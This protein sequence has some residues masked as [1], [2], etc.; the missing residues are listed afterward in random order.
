MLG[1]YKLKEDSRFI[2]GVTAFGMSAGCVVQVKQVDK[3]YRKVL[4][5]FGGRMIDWHSDSILNKFE[6]IEGE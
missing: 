6:K 1:K 4:A 5:D 2:C 3:E